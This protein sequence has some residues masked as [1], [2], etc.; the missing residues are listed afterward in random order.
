M[1]RA[2]WMIPLVVGLGIAGGAFLWMPGP[3]GPASKGPSAAASAPGGKA[4]PGAKA[5]GPGA[6]P[7]AGTG[8]SGG[9]PAMGTPGQ[10]T[11]AGDVTPEQARRMVEEIRGLADNTDPIGTALGG[12]DAVL[13]SGPGERVSMRATDLL[14]RTEA[15]LEQLGKAEQ[16]NASTV[17]AVNAA[18][19]RYEDQLTAIQA[20]ATDKSMT[21]PQALAAVETAG[22]TVTDDL[23][24]AAGPNAATEVAKQIGQPTGDDVDLD[25]WGI[26][27]EE[28][29]A[30]VEAEGKAK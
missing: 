30:Q 13:G 17:A 5:A 28:W 6:N 18:V 15:T 2:Q 26:P 7:Q 19:D 9:A 16:W 20:K 3:T 22:K 10:L 4:A 24:K 29:A 1:S 12:D 25:G 23:T 11:P 8:S 27:F 21:L 14:R